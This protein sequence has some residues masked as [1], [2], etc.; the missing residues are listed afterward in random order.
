VWIQRAGGGLTPLEPITYAAETDFQELLAQHPEVLSATISSHGAGWLLV[1]RELAIG[2]ESDEERTIW[3][4][5]H[6]FIDDE[7]TPVLVEVKRS[8]DPRARREV[9][10]QM[11]DYAASFR[12]SWTAESLRV[13]WASSPRPGAADSTVEMDRFLGTTAFEDE[14]A[15]WS[16]VA[17]RISANRLRLLFVADRLSPTLVRIIEYLNEQLA[18]TEVLG[19][20]VVPHSDGQPG[21]LTAYVPFVR[22]QTSAVPRSKQPSTRR[23]RDEFDEILREYHGDESVRAVNQLTNAISESL[24]GFPSIGTDARSPTLLLNLVTS[25]TGRTFWPLG[26]KPR[27]GKVA[28]QLRWLANHPAFEDEEVRD[29]FRARV[30]DAV[31]TEVEGRLDGFPGFPVTALVAPGAVDRLVEVLRWTLA[32]AGSPGK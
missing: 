31:N 22:G 18:T 9:V 24:G 16:E 8:S 30:A 20:E 6:L 4:L 2:F 21:G 7:G 25:G 29:E 19:V 14:D 1:K 27:A 23:S 15:F 26:I 12:H 11:L 28:L 13:Q 5:D 32:K 3:S 17:T 10:A